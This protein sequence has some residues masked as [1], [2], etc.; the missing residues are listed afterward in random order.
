MYFEY[1]KIE[2]SYWTGEY[3]LNQIKT[4][5]LIIREGLYPGYKLLLIFDNAISHTIY[6]KNTL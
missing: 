6:A 5:T 2:E 3:L 4:K 1:R